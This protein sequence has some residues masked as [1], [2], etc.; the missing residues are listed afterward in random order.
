[1]RAIQ[2]NIN[3]FLF[4]PNKYFSIPIFQRPYSWDDVNILEFLIDLEK[5]KNSSR[6]HYFGS[7]VYIAGNE[8]TIIDGQQ[9]ATTSLLM[10]TAIYHLVKKDSTKSKT[11]A[12]QINE[13]FLFNKYGTEKNRLKLKTVTTDN[14][15]FENI[16]SQKK[17]SEEHKLSK[18][19]KA[20]EI[21]FDY[22]QDKKDL[23]N[24]IDGLENFEIIDVSI[25]HNDDN[26]QKIFESINSTGKALNDG[27]KIRNFALMLNDSESMEFVYNEFWK[28]I[29][30]SLTTINN[31]DISDFFKNYLTSSQQRE[32]KLRQVYPGFKKVYE[33]KIGSNHSDRIKIAEFYE[34]L[35][36]YLEVYKSLK[37]GRVHSVQ[38]KP[39]SDSI[40]RIN[41]L[42]YEVVYPF[43]MRVLL[44]YKDK[45]LEKES[46]DY[47]LKSIEAYLTRRVIC[48]VPS[49]GLNKYFATLD[50]DIMHALKASELKLSSYP[51]VFSFDILEKTQALRFPSDSEVSMSIPKN[52]FY[53]QRKSNVF[54]V[55]S[56]ID[57]LSQSNESFLLKQQGDPNIVNQITI[58]HVMPQNLT[59]KWK[60]KLGESYKM[61]H[62]EFLHTL[63]NLTLTGYNPSYSNKTFQ[64]KQKTKNGFFDSALKIN[65]YFKDIEEWGKTEIIDR[66]KWWDEQ[67][68][69]LWPTPVTTYEPP[70]TENDI[71]LLK[72]KDLTGYGIRSITIFGDRF[73]VQTWSEA[74]DIITE[75]AT[76]RVNGWKNLLLAD[77]FTSKFFTENPENFFNPYEINDSGYY[78]E[79]GLST[80]RKLNLIKSIIKVLEIK[81]LEIVAGVIPP[82]NIA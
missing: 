5:V 24:Y 81:E 27:D 61:I 21:F 65:A 15:I 43:L 8:S 47:I 36:N 63:P 73:N 12:E 4:T 53:A 50:R 1:M 19:Y 32:Y 76:E 54:F 44:R 6:N 56:S 48:G 18:L 74:L 38:Y 78:V 16:Y 11:P 69:K 40:F 30:K 58:E 64:E 59:Q 33:E 45:E 68:I 80:V 29:E 60:A 62:D 22:F 51:D 35:Q 70:K 42:N 41:Y 34:G 25:D 82:K 66:A 28:D 46:V 52:Q 72:A 79:T 2:S 13:Q 9:R 77:E 7:I 37:T 49:A 26:P 39:F 23:H 14:E 3:I 71:D 17:L 67:I 31:D 20:Y 55:L 57:D 75:Q 10:I